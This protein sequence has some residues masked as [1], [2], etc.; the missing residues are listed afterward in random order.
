MGKRSIVNMETGVIEDEL[1]EGDRILRDRSK[2]H[3]RDLVSVNTGKAYIKIYIDS[4]TKMPED[5]S[6]IGA[7]NTVLFAIIPMIQ[8]ETGLIAHD[9]GKYVNENAIMRITG[10]SRM[11]V[12]KSMEKL[13]QKR[14]L[15]KVRTGRDIKF[16]ANPYI[17]MRG[18]MINKTL[19]SMFA[20]SR[21]AKGE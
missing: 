10:L 11:S 17:F 5:G 18:R 6:F 9:N 21:F 12:Y 3:L 13:V 1:G 20:T 2:D 16:Y 14:I 4:F 19:Q 15:A 7:D 8:Y